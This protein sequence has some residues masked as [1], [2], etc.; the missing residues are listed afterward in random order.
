MV[1][2]EVFTHWMEI[3]RQI[4]ERDVPPVSVHHCNVHTKCGRMHVTKILSIALIFSYSFSGIRLLCFELVLSQKNQQLMLYVFL[5]PCI[6]G[7][8]TH[9][10]IPDKYP[11]GVVF[12]SLCVDSV[13]ICTLC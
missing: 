4:V 10:R 3:V 5:L 6:V 8:W 13:H 7:M 12:K 9:C 1:T 11:L 2:K